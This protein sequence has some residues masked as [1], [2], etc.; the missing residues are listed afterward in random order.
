MPVLKKKL[1]ESVSQFSSKLII[2]SG[3]LIAVDTETTGLMAYA[4][5][6]PF[7]VSFCNE[8]GETGYVQWLVD[9]KTRKVRPDK[10]DLKILGK[11]LADD[12]ISKVFFNSSFDLRMFQIGLGLKVNGIIEDSQIS[13]H[14][15]NTAERN[16]KLKYLCKRFGIMEDDD[17]KALKKLVISCRLKAKKLGWK[18]HENVEPDYWIP[19]Q[20]NPKDD[21]CE[22]YAVKDA[23]R[24]MELWKQTV[25]FM[26]ESGRYESYLFEMHK[27]API[28]R[29]MEDRGMTI[30]PDVIFDEID[31]CTFEAEK[32]RRSL[33]KVAK[34]PD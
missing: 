11:F 23:I 17:E 14:V 6:Q 5:D 8:N 29:E 10:D 4:G 22:I 25:E 18:I 28:L 2:P 7:A 30:D 32:A 21:T 19:K 20:L 12:S 24:T 31:N 3:K 9:P 27:L 16:Y 1:V 33:C 13:M 26:H 15:C 34:K